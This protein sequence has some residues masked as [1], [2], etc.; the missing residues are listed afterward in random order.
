MP[1]TSQDG[2]RRL[3][4]ANPGGDD[5]GGFYDDLVDGKGS[6]EKSRNIPD[7]PMN[8]KI[9]FDSDSSDDEDEDHA[10]EEAN[11]GCADQKEPADKPKEPSDKPKEASE[12]Y[13]DDLTAEDLKELL[14]RKKRLFASLD[15]GCNGRIFIQM[16]KRVGDPGPIEIV[17]MVVGCFNS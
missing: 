10:S 16:H 5:S 7:R 11:E 13:I 14:N 6:N 4:Q 1:T 17:E 8:R 3:G 15:T 12:E 9:K 2:S